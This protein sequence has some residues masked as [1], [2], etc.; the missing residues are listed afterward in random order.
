M[1]APGYMHSS[2]AFPMVRLE[3][4]VIGISCFSEGHARHRA[5]YTTLL[6]PLSRM[7][8]ECCRERRERREFKETAAEKLLKKCHRF[9]QRG[10]N[11]DWWMFVGIDSLSST[12][13]VTS[14]LPTTTLLTYMGTYGQDVR[15]LLSPESEALRIQ[16]VTVNDAI[17][18]AKA[19][20][21]YF[22][23]FWC[24]RGLNRTYNI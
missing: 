14:S 7:P 21:K 4:V 11:D 10:S 2:R 15:I 8:R 3:S 13:F 18:G 12:H 19:R 23:V 9:E 24:A 6:V 20:S 5:C 17:V 1:S 16:L 22:P